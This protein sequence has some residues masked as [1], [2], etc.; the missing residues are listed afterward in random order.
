MEPVVNGLEERYQNQ[1][2]FQSFNATSTKGQEV[3]RFYALPGHPSYVLINPEGEMLWTGFGEQLQEDI[4][5]NLDDALQG[6][7]PTP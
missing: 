7:S 6:W 4:A 1:I 2:E 3:F 5:A